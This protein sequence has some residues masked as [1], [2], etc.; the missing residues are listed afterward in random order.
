MKGCLS[1]T[2][3]GWKQSDN[4]FFEMIHK[5]NGLYMYA[6]T[7]IGQDRVEFKFLEQ[8]HHFERARVKSRMIYSDYESTVTQQIKQYQVVKR[9]C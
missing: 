3:P 2:N 4:C 5:S 1:R 7:E 9:V 8:G 6:S